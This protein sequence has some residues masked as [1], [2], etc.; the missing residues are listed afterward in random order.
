MK[1]IAVALVLLYSCKGE[2]VTNL[3]Q[4]ESVK[5][6]MVVVESSQ[7]SINQRVENLLDSTQGV[8]KKINEIKVIKQEN[9]V[10]KKELIE[11]KKELYMVKEQL[12]DTVSENLPIKKKKNFIQ[13]VVSTIKKD[14][15]R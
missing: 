13:K 2:S 4:E 7:D 14:T 3:K 9:M 5:D 11:T 15:T 1:K 10:L 8:E 6:T 12:N